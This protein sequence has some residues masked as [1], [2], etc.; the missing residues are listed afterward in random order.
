MENIRAVTPNHT[1]RVESIEMAKCVQHKKK[2]LIQSSERIKQFESQLRIQ[3]NHLH[4][5]DSVMSQHEDRQAKK[6]IALYLEEKA[7]R[8]EE[9]AKEMKLERK[10]AERKRKEEREC[11]KERLRQKEDEKKKT[12]MEQL[13]SRVDND[14]SSQSLTGEESSGEWYSGG[15][16]NDSL[17]FSSSFSSTASL[18]EHV[19]NVSGWSSVDTTLQNNNSKK[20]EKQKSGAKQ[21]DLNTKTKL[22]ESKQLNDDVVQS[23]LKSSE[24]ETH[25]VVTRGTVDSK[26]VQSNQRHKKDEGNKSLKTPAPKSHQKKALHDQQQETHQNKH[27]SQKKGKSLQRGSHV[28]R[29]PESSQHKNDSRQHVQLNNEQVR[30]KSQIQSA[31]TTGL[32]ALFKANKTGISQETPPKHTNQ[33]ASNSHIPKNTVQSTKQPASEPERKIILRKKRV[34][35]NDTKAPPAARRVSSSDALLE[36]S[37]SHHNN[38]KPATIQPVPASTRL[39]DAPP[40]MRKSI[41]Y[42]GKLDDQAGVYDLLA[43]KVKPPSNPQPR[44]KKDSRLQMG[45]QT[46]TFDPATR[47]EGVQQQQQQQSSDTVS[48]SQPDNFDFSSNP[49]YESGTAAKYNIAKSSSGNGMTRSTDKKTNQNVPVNNPRFQLQS[50]MH[51]SYMPHNTNQKTNN[52]AITRQLHAQTSQMGKPVV[53]QVHPVSRHEFSSVW[54][55]YES[56]SSETERIK[57]VLSDQSSTHLSTMSTVSAKN[58]SSS[59]HS[60]SQ[61]HHHHR[62]Q[63][64]SQM[65]QPPHLDNH[66]MYP[67]RVDDS[68]H[69]S[70][71]PAPRKRYHSQ[72]HDQPEILN[73]CGYRQVIPHPPPHRQTTRIPLQSGHD[74]GALTSYPRF[75]RR[76]DHQARLKGTPTARRH[77]TKQLGVLPGTGQLAQFTKQVTEN[78]IAHGNHHSNRQP[79]VGS[80]V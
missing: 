53:K 16:D 61:H 7:Q 52:T 50:H 60:D 26:S 3:K 29:K 8:E 12:R 20:E 11:V 59:S 31:P 76:E 48:R 30:T 27:G 21:K 78:H 37:H 6:V 54:Q 32:H 44:E 13:R 66:I 36:D 57:S 73:T 69:H 17:R 72:P 45:F 46:P 71:L 43:K 2:E 22:D 24:S 34:P 4:K 35:L 56:D 74:D 51:Q 70:R 42:I 49:S 79:N 5:M 62:S 1:H 14:Q 75:Q 63:I 39:A 64:I 80:L 67:S 25:S 38:R 23:H 47:Q 9:L 28:K 55:Q 15:G 65:L 33:S 77:R 40:N 58:S 41:G 10:V 19:R 68:T 18:L